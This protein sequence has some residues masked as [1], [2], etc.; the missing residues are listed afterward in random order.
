ML[1]GGKRAKTSRFKPIQNPKRISLNSSA[2]PSTRLPS[3]PSKAP[4][5]ENQENVLKIPLDPSSSVDT[6]ANNEDLLTNILLKLPAKSLL[7]FRCV[8]RQWRTIISDPEFRRRHIRSIR[9]CPTSDFLFFSP[10]I[11]PNEIDLL[12]LSGDGLDSVGNLSSPLRRSLEGRIIR[13]QACNGLLCI[14][15]MVNYIRRDLIVYNPTTSEHRT[16]PWP[17]EGNHSPTIVPYTSIAFD[18]LTSDYYKLLDVSFDRGLRFFIYSS[19]SGVWRVGGAAVAGTFDSDYYFDKGVFW[20]GD[21]HFMGTEFCTLCFDVENECLR[22]SMPR[23]PIRMEVM[24]KWDIKYFGETGG[25]LYAIYL[26]RINTAVLSDVFELKRDYSQWVV[27]YRFD[28]SHLVTYYPEM[29]SCGCCTPCFIAD[30]EGKNARIVI[31]LKGKFILYDINRVFVKELVEVGPV[32]SSVDDWGNSKWY[33]WYEAYQHV[34]TF[35]SV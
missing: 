35:A 29:K 33:R 1:P 4:I 34:G 13:L 14:Q 15:F 8:S 17:N 7:C 24:G 27:K 21:V 28:F 2:S 31:S 18:P 30:E 11:K 10:Y 32:G 12:S 22:P 23:I 5:R 20:N 16:I 19:E 9:C 26:N 6:I 3:S 25:N